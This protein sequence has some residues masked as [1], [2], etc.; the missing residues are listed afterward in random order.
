[1]AAAVA[2][3]N[4]SA[5][6]RAARERLLAAEVEERRAHE[7]LAAARR[8]LPPG[9]EVPEDYVFERAGADG[10]PEPVRMS[11]LF[12]RGDT[13][14]VYSFMFGPDRDAPCMGCTSMLDGIDG[15][16]RHIVERINFAVVAESPVPRLLE[17]AERRGWSWLPLLSTAGNSYNRDY[18]GKDPDGYDQP[19]L[20]VF[21]RTGATIRHFWGS[22][23]LYQPM[24]PG[25][26][27]RHLDSIDLFW[28]MFDFTPGGR[29]EDSPPDLAPASAG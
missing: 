28:N 8:E 19:M 18:H 20:N 4:E 7:A 10:T 14:A 11:E 23:L 21:Q 5:E 12:A 3:P 1:M 2:F 27:M 25:Q 24:E 29:G 26:E 22:E 16:T 13:L 6:Y 15:A 17:F 9:G